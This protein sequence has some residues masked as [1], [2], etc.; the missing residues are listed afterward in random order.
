VLAKAEKNQDDDNDS[1]VTSVA[2]DNQSEER[3]K[4]FDFFH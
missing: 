3:D 4:V 1:I 2:S